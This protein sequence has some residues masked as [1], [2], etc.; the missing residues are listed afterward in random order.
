MDETDTQGGRIMTGTTLV[1]DSDSNDLPWHYDWIEA[2]RFFSQEMRKYEAYIRKAGDSAEVADLVQIAV[3]EAQD[4]LRGCRG[5]REAVGDGVA[6][7]EYWNHRSFRGAASIFAKRVVRD[8]FRKERRPDRNRPNGE[9]GAG[10]NYRL[11]ATPLS[12]LA[13]RP[14]E[15][16]EGVPFDRADESYAMSLEAGAREALR[17]AAETAAAN[18]SAV[19]GDDDRLILTEYGNWLLDHP[20]THGLAAHLGAIFADRGQNLAGD[21][22]RKRVE[23]ATVRLFDTL[24]AGKRDALTGCLR[25]QSSHFSTP[26]LIALGLFLNLVGTVDRRRFM[27][28]VIEG[29]HNSGYASVSGWEAGRE[30]SRSVMKAFSRLAERFRHRHGRPFWAN[31]A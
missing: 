29:V 17:K 26:E 27:P 12:Q 22:L 19:L 6:P 31:E 25:E 5:H 23:S 7:E 18:G 14:D 16:G 13:S 30:A 9:E 3:M 1:N 8:H 10:R 4:Y 28:A 11:W 15:S 2:D 21:A 24:V 20:S